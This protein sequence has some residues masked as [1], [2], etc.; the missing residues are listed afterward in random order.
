MCFCV[1]RFVAC[2]RIVIDGSEKRKCEGGFL[3]FRV[4]VFLKSAVRNFFNKFALV[5]FLCAI[6]VLF[7]KFARVALR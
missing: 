2:D 1:T 4:R 7:L 5:L 6:G 3:N